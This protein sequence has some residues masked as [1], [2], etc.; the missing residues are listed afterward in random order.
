[1]DASVTGHKYFSFSFV[2]A[3]MQ[4]MQLGPEL[5]Q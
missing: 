4:K 5:R 1:M 2:E 3:I